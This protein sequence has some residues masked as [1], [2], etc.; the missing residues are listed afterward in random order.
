MKTATPTRII[1][2]GDGCLLIRLVL[3][4]FPT[5]DFPAID[6]NM[7]PA[8]IF[9]IGHKGQL[10]ADTGGDLIQVKKVLAVSAIGNLVDRR[11]SHSLSAGACAQD[12]RKSGGIK[13]SASSA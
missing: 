10:P 11:Y 8:I 4:V 2:N 3:S 9:D 12:K 6:Q 7:E 13:C 1:L 5:A